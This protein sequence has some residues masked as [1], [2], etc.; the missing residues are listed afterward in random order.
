MKISLIWGEKCE[1]LNL[2]NRREFIRWASKIVPEWKGHLEIS[3]RKTENNRCAPL[4]SW[5]SN[6]W[7]WI[8]LTMSFTKLWYSLSNIYCQLLF[9]IVKLKLL[10]LSNC[11]RAS[12][13]Q[14]FWVISGP[15]CGTTYNAKPQ[16]LIL[17]SGTVIIGKS[18]WSI[19]FRR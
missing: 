15:F 6:W 2:E 13:N 9:K 14:Y 19:N 10:L 11:G 18:I 4:I 8:T 3:S 5:T 12:Y 16:T 7:F 17:K 1:K